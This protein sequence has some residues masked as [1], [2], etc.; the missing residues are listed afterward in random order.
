[1]QR[2]RLY[3]KT[4][5]FW[6]QNPHPAW[7]AD[8]SLD[9]PAVVQKR[10]Q[11][12]KIK[13]QLTIESAC[14]LQRPKILETASSKWLSFAEPQRMKLAR[15]HLLGKPGNSVHLLD[16]HLRDRRDKSSSSATKAVM[17]PGQQQI[18]KQ[19]VMCMLNPRTERWMRPMPMQTCH[20]C[21]GWWRRFMIWGLWFVFCAQDREVCACWVI[22]MCFCISQVCHEGLQPASLPQPPTTHIPTFKC[23]RKEKKISH[24]L[25]WI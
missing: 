5:A 8:Q 12:C 6:H 18:H 2:I 3:L 25:E 10:I 16:Q 19:H 14:H 1:M 13:R 24:F 20:V 21:Q 17:L 9:I 23:I 22:P 4:H 15:Y 11:L 7:A